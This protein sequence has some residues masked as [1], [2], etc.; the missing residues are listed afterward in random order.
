MSLNRL[1]YINKFQWVR[2]F[3]I[4]WISLLPCHENVDWREILTSGT[5]LG[6]DIN[7]TASVDTAMENNGDVYSLLLSRILNRYI[8]VRI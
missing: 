3:L 8:E 1:I 4:G 2:D 7:P 6:T 5:H